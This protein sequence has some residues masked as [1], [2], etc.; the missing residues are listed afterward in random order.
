[1]PNV[2]FQKIKHL[3]LDKNVLELCWDN[4]FYPA[5]YDFDCIT[6]TNLNYMNYVVQE[7]ELRLKNY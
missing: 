5:S 7:G 6:K 4:D 2:K 3:K 1:M